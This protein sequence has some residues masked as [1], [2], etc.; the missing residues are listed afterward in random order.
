MP[1]IDMTSCCNSF[2]YRIGRRAGEQGPRPSVEN[3]AEVE[4]STSGI[5][6]SHKEP[7]NNHAEDPPQ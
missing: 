1:N 6:S 2:S 4:K 5:N 3:Q 7:Q